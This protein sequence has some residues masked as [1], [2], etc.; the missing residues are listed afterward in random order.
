MDYPRLYRKRLIPYECVELKKD[1]ILQYDDRIIVTSWDTIR[2]KKELHHGFS[3][4]YIKEGWKV[5][6]F[7][8]ED[9]SRMYVYCD[10]V[11]YDL[12]KEQN[13]L[14]VTDLLADVIIY[15]D[16]FVKVV[17]L[18]ELAQAVREGL[19][20]GEQL[21]ICLVNVDS[22]LNKI[23]SGKLNELTAPLERFINP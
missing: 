6:Y 8:R 11:S 21:N 20:T 5:S 1:R 15:P 22:L 12:D 18:D 13:T 3:C 14:T 4:F 16:G 10:I 2:P 23:Y 7:C 17:D 9:N 19:I